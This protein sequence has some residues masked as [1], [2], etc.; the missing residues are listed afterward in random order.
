VDQGLRADRLEAP[1]MASRLC[2]ALSKLIKETW[3]A[4]LLFHITTGVT[5][6]GFEESIK[7]NMNDRFMYAFGVGCDDTVRGGLLHF[8][9]TLSKWG[10]SP[11]CHVVFATWNRFSCLQKVYKRGGAGSRAPLNYYF[12]PLGFFFHRAQPKSFH[13]SPNQ[14]F[15]LEGYE[16][17]PNQST[18]Q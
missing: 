6:S 2:T 9:I 8:G 1:P 15:H 11:D 10:Y 13:E 17:F 5:T 4:A 16:L 14:G 7:I 12:G 18:F 3:T